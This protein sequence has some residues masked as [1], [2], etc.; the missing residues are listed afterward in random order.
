[1]I[2]LAESLIMHRTPHPAQPTAY[3][4]QIIQLVQLQ[5]IWEQKH[6][7][8]VSTVRAYCTIIADLRKQHQLELALHLPYGQRS[9]KAISAS[10]YEHFWSCHGHVQIRQ[11]LVPALPVGLA[12]M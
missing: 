2:R 1:M 6:G 11:A 10:Q 7:M 4:T 3:R 9:V 12:E 5:G 8:S